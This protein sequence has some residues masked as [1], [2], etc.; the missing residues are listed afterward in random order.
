MVYEGPGTDID[1]G[2]HVV[3][4]Y[5]FLTNNS[6]DTLKKHGNLLVSL[7]RYDNALRTV[8]E[9]KFGK[10]LGNFRG[11]KLNNKEI[12]LLGKCVQELKNE[13]SRLT[14]FLTFTER[15]LE[16]DVKGDPV[17]LIIERATV[18]DQDGE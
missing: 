7:E 15:R 11:R 4:R 3:G 18:G 2:Q 14:G 12:T 17:C 1:R 16:P 9:V 13:L 10:S 8:S 5:G 6:L